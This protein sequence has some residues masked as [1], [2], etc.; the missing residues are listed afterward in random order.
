MDFKKLIE[1]RPMF[2]FLTTVVTS[3]GCGFAAQEVYFRLSDKTVL[4]NGSFYLKSEIAGRI[5]YNNAKSL[6]QNL[7]QEG[8]KLIE[9][10]QNDPSTLDQANEFSLKA[11]IILD[12][13]VDVRSMDGE[14]M[15]VGRSVKEVQMIM[16]ANK[17]Y[18]YEGI[19]DQQKLNRVV[20]VLGALL[21]TFNLIEKGGDK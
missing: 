14:Q 10:T 4:K 20:N 5:N 2:F 11:K 21:K 9:S 19:N 1:S 17:E 13:F 7:K 18:G 6:I 15:P 12:T 3:F 16:A 8:D